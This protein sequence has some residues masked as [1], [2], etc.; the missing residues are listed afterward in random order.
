MLKYIFHR[1]GY[2]GKVI[3]HCGFT[4]KLCTPLCFKIFNS[5][6]LMQGGLPFITNIKALC[7]K[8]GEAQSTGGGKAFHMKHEVCKQT[9]VSAP[10]IKTPLSNLVTVNCLSTCFTKANSEYLLDEKDA[11]TAYKYHRSGSLKRNSLKKW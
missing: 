6:L 9:P 8:L 10:I 4:S 3:T 7:Q 5:V 11:K 1:Y 2:T